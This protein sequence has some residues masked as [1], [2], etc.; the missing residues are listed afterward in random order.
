[1]VYIPQDWLVDKENENKV[2]ELLDTLDNDL[3]VEGED[4]EKQVIESLEALG[5]SIIIDKIKS[6]IFNFGA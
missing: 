2:H 1:M 6:N 4:K 3:K 5:E